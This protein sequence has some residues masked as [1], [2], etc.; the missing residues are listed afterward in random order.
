ME[1]IT[2]EFRN[3]NEAST[4]LLE[5]NLNAGISNLSQKIDT[6]ELNL[7]ACNIIIIILINNLK[8]LEKVAEENIGQIKIL[9]VEKI[10]HLDDITKNASNEVIS[11]ISKKSETIN[12]YI[13]TVYLFTK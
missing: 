5:N 13:H 2:L 10:N 1:K 4:Q 8:R 6:N 3:L 12:T 11:E 7:K 9:F